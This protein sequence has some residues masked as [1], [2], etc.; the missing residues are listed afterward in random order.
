LIPIR[1]V[2]KA[3]PSRVAVRPVAAWPIVARQQMLVLYNDIPR[4]A[5]GIILV[6]HVS[7]G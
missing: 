1:R 5:K 2:I 7:L 3:T 4:L 6:P